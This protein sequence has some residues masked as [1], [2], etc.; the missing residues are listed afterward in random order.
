MSKLNILSQIS[1][2]F[3]KLVLHRTC[4]GKGKEKNN[5][6]DV[7]NFAENGNKTKLDGML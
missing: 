1:S 5:K 3:L 4:S 2:I 7:F 6:S